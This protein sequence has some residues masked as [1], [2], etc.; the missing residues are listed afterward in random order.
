MLV[1]TT[2]RMWRILH[3]NLMAANEIGAHESFTSP[4]ILL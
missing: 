1:D 2:V 4:C 3:L